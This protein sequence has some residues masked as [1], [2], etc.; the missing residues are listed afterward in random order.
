MD[1]MPLLGPSRNAA[2]TTDYVQREN[3]LLNRLFSEG[4]LDRQSYIMSQAG[5]D[6]TYPHMVRLDKQDPSGEMTKR[7]IADLSKTKTA[8]VGLNAEAPYEA[9]AV[10]IMDTFRRL[11][12]GIGI[13]QAPVSYPPSM[14]RDLSEIRENPYTQESIDKLR[15]H[16][17]K[18]QEY[19][20]YLN[21]LRGKGIIK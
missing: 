10:K 16:S 17:K 21:D 6:A 11:Q 3:D 19:G 13:P 4:I 1:A 15:Y 12:P 9:N 2:K 18:M 7:F 5:I 20:Q 8:A 14:A